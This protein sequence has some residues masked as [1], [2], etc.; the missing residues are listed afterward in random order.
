MHPGGCRER[1]KVHP[2][3]WQKPLF[4]PIRFLASRSVYY[5]L[6][7][8]FYNMPAMS[9]TIMRAKFLGVFRQP[10]RPEYRRNNEIRKFELSVTYELN[11]F[12]RQLK[13]LLWPYVSNPR[14]IEALIDDVHDDAWRNEALKDTLKVH[15]GPKG[16]YVWFFTILEGFRMVLNEMHSKLGN[17]DEVRTTSTLC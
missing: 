11:T 5:L 10:K 6:V 3:F 7:R 12:K 8:N 17:R 16:Q 15:F 9:C 2:F 13:K 14:Q 1:K 4:F